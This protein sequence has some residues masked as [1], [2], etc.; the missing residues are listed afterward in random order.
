MS[1][2]SF[3]VDLQGETIG[4]GRER[5]ERPEGT[6]SLSADGGTKSRDKWRYY[7]SARK[8]WPGGG[9]RKGIG[10]GRR[11]TVRQVWLLLNLQNTHRIRGSQ[12]SYHVDETLNDSTS[13]GAKRGWPQRNHCWRRRSPREVLRG[14]KSM[15]QH[16]VIWGFFQGPFWAMFCLLQSVC[17]SQIH[18]WTIS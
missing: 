10:R 1:K 11:S 14:G 16:K 6:A 5:G 3:L 7:K 2:L 4:I 15:A 13:E 9:S 8:K 18:F 12:T 17:P